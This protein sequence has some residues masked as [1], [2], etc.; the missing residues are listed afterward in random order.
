MRC[1]RKDPAQRLRDIADGRFQIEEVLSDP[2]TSTTVAT[3]AGTY[4]E[5]AAWIAAALLSGHDAVPGHAA[6]DHLSRHADSISFPVFPPEKAEFS[7]SCQHHVQ[8][9]LVCALTR[10]P[11]AGVQCRDAGRQTDALAAIAGS[12]GRAPARRNRGRPGSLLVSGQPVDWLLR[13]RD[14]E[15]D[16]RRRRSR[17]ESSTQT[18]EATSA[19]PRGAH[20]T[21]FS[22]RAEWQGIVS[23]DASRR[24]HHAGH[25]CR[26][27][28]PREH[29]SKSI[30]SCQTAF[31]SCTPSSAAA[32][33]MVCTS[34][35]WMARR[36]NCLLHVLTSAVYAQPGYVL[37]VD[38]DTL[39]GQ[40]FDAD[41]LELKG[42]PFFVAE[43]VGRNTL[44]HERRVGLA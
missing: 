25:G 44:L 39:L 18:I 16:S 20:E 21:R 38:G 33:E 9:S 32:I 3:P 34:G 17:A 11:R 30:V 35:R 26:Y 12:R 14:A 15:A 22:W 19:V 42:Q 28:S 13:R 24:N 4:R 37:F 40:A 23:M 5:W 29:A 10:R 36:R 1:L 6:F 7:A 31:T 8:R 2:G 27:V 43:H 41:R